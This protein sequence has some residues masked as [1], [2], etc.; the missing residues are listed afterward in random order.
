MQCFYYQ[1]L[2]TAAENP[3]IL[4]TEYHALKLIRCDRN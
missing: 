4:R 3:Q 2:L 1:T